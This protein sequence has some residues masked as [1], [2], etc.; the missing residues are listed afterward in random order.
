M[1]AKL[2]KSLFTLAVVS[3]APAM[4]QQLQLPAP[5]PAASV[6]Q[7]VGLTDITVDY[8]SP[9]VKGRKIFGELVPLERPWRAGANAAT[10]V[11]FSKDVTFGG[12]AVPAGS[13]S[14]IALPSARGWQIA[15]NKVTDGLWQGKTYDAKQ[16]VARVPAT[17]TAIPARERMAFLFNNTTD[18]GTSFDLEWEQLRI[19]VPVK[20]D[21]NAQTAANIKNTLDSAWRPHAQAASYTAERNEL[22]TALKY[23]DTSLAIQ[24]NWYNNWVK[25]QIWEKKGN[26]AEAR[27]FAQTSW[28]LG[29]KDPNFFFKDAVQK[30]LTD[31]KNKT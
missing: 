18:T 16:D 22:D 23:V 15:L 17:T 20:V 29:N 24:S 13:Y 19:S 11:T 21:T 14:L 7:T 25:A 12:K 27:K 8:S 5:S 30:A 9:A 26:Y 28:D 4:A 2:L 3:A 6:K 31:W 1:T 10:K